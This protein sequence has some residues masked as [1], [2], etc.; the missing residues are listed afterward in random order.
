MRSPE[1]RVFHPSDS[2]ERSEHL[3][4][5]ATHSSG[6]VGAF[7]WGSHHR[8]HSADCR[9]VQGPTRL[10][11]KKEFLAPAAVLARHKGR[12]VVA[13]LLLLGGGGVFRPKTSNK[14]R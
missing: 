1:F 13:A 9:F 12:H 11:E 4:W 6:L 7:R 10:K 3:R 5:I 2:T 8:T 14:T